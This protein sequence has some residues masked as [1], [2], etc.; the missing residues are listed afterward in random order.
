MLI[1]F[2]VAGGC[3]A[4]TNGMAPFILRILISVID[5][6]TDLNVM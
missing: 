3:T 1:Q 6:L 5:P 4:S 2:V